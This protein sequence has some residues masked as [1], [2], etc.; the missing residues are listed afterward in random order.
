MLYYEYLKTVATSMHH[1]RAQLHSSYIGDGE[2][3]EISPSQEACMNDNGHH[4]VHIN[5]CSVKVSYIKHIS[6]T[7]IN[8][9]LCQ[10]CVNVT[11]MSVLILTHVRRLIFFTSSATS[12]INFYKFV[13][14]K[15]VKV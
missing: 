14:E 15:H 7:L 10:G 9:F 5:R 4:Y 11:I 2:T 3:L 13:R 6:N 1:F 8:G 12:R